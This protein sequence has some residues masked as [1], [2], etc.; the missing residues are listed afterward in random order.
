MSY[1]KK[2]LEICHKIMVFTVVPFAIFCIATDWSNVNTSESILDR[3]LV[4]WIMLM[5]LLSE[6]LK[7]YSN[8]LQKKIDK[9]KQ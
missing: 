2:F 6:V 3:V 5:L 1:F 8:Y 4:V 9:S 7:M